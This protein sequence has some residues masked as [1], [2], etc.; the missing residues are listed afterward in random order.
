VIIITAVKRFN[1]L[2]PA[3]V[4][5]KC[6]ENKKKYG[7]AESRQKADVIKTFFK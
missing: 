7:F 2:T 5:K 6:K 4:L 1:E 3:A